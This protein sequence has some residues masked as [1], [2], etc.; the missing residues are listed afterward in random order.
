MISKK[1]LHFECF[2]FLDFLSLKNSDLIF[3][4]P[5]SSATQPNLNGDPLLGRN[6]GVE[7]H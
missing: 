4:Q 3:T 2:K 1:N 7:N 6:P 5:Q